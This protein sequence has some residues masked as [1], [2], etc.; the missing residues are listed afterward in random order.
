MRC[1]LF[2]IVL[3]NFSAGRAFVGNLVDGGEQRELLHI[4]GAL[5]YFMGLL[6]SK[7][8]LQTKEKI[9]AAWL[10][11][12]AQLDNEVC[13]PAASARSG[14]PPQSCPNPDWDPIAS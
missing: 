6:G 10:I 2:G 4:T 8:A 9:R 14:C 12:F 13:L 5:Q 1:Y 7:R 3:H 11:L